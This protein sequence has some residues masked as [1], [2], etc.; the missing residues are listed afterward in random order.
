M[1]IITLYDMQ[2]IAK[3]VPESVTFKLPFLNHEK[4]EVWSAKFNELLKECGC[5][6]GQQYLLYATP[7]YIIAVVSLS[8]YTSIPKKIIIG[9]FLSL[10]IIT[11]LAGKAVGLYQRNRKMQKLMNQ[12][13][14]EN[15]LPEIK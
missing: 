1:D 9:S 5:S 15:N 7:I 14:A 6:S 13:Y 12:F 4:N 2:L 11:G 3:N 10:L 8:S